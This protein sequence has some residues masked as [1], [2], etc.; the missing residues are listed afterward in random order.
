MTEFSKA[1]VDMGRGLALLLCCS[2]GVAACRDRSCGPGT[3]PAQDTEGNPICAA[4]A[5]GA[6]TI[7]CDADAGV[8]LVDGNRCLSVVRCGPGT[9]LDPT[10]HQCVPVTLAPH[11]PPPCP[12]P[13]AGHICVA[14]TLRNLVDGSFL[15]GETVTVSLYDLAAFAFGPPP[16]PLAEVQATDTYLVPSIATP[17]YLLV[18]THDAAGGTTYQATGIS[19]IAGSDGVYRLDAYVLT[20]AQ[21][22]AWQLPSSVAA[23]GPLFFRFFDDPAPPTNART[24]TETHPVA[25]VKL[26]LA[27]ANDANAHYFGATLAAIDATATASG[28]TG[29][30]I[31]AATGTPPLSFG[32][33]GGGITW[34]P[35]PSLPVPTIV[36][37]DFFHPQ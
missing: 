4:V 2:L 21:Y 12:T 8:S 1:E 32:A 3:Q 18:V 15:S 35:H 36:M 24:P 10:T 30:V 14:G 31:T 19:T 37:V 20:Q 28:A 26:Q 34:G 11:E 27:G 9:Q 25:G 16:A 5:V 22:A 29:G 13:S 7:A 6:G 17:M 33:S 23:Q